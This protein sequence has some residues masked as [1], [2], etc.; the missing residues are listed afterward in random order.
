MTITIDDRERILPR[1]Q[2]ESP[3]LM[4]SR[5]FAESCISKTINARLPS[6]RPFPTQ[7]DLW[8]GAV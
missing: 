5:S 6:D 8:S 2:A 4:A 7:I 3:I 1:R